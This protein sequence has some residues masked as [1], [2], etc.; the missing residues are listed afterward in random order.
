MTINYY[1]LCTLKMGE[2][3]A[4]INYLFSMIH[5]ILS[6]AWIMS[7][8]ISH[9]E[10]EKWRQSK[11]GWILEKKFWMNNLHSKCMKNVSWQSLLNWC[12]MIWKIAAWCLFIPLDKCKY[13]YF[14]SGTEYFLRLLVTLKNASVMK[15]IC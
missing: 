7:P 10:L 3:L 1:N 11:G 6:N 12:C 2:W 5:W 4:F 14:N 9:K 15:L 13:C 8:L